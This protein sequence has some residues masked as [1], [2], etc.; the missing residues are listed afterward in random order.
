MEEGK[1]ASIQYLNFE[2]ENLPPPISYD[3]IRGIRNQVLAARSRKGVIY[4]I[5][6]SGG[7]S[8]YE[9]FYKEKQNHI[10][11]LLR[12]DFYLHYLYPDTGSERMVSSCRGLV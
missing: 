2:G 11:V 3:W 7:A 9:R 6:R 5:Y 8:D 10:F 4:P 12:G 1:I